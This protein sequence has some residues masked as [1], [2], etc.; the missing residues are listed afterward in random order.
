MKRLHLPFLFSIFLLLLSSCLFSQNEKFTMRQ[1]ACGLSQPWEIKFG[2]DGFLWATEAHSYQITRIDPATGNAELLID[3]SAKKNFPNF[4]LA[5]KF[6]QG[7]LQ[8]I[9]FH[10]SFNTNPYFYVAYVYRFD[11]CL[12]DTLG[13]YFKTKI[14]RY[15]Y[16]MRTKTLSNEMVIVDTIPG[17][18]DHNG[19][20]LAIGPISEDM[21]FLFYSVGDMAAGHLGNGARTHNGQN[22]N[23]YEGKILRFNLTPDSDSAYFNSWI[24]NNNPFNTAGKQSAVWSIGHRNPQGLAFSPTGILYES[25]HGPYSDDEINIIKP[26]YNYGFPLIMGYTDGNY[27]GSKAGAGSGVPFVTSEVA[28]QALIERTYPYGEPIGSFFPASRRDVSTFYTND[29]NNTPPYPNYYLQYPTSAPSGIDY[30]DS[31][32][33]PGWKNSILMA[34]LK[35]ANVYRLKLSNDGSAI[36]GDTIAYFQ[37]LGRFRDL[38][39]S[40]DGTKIY[41]STDTVGVVKGAPGV[42]VV[43]PNKGCILEFTL[44]STGT[45]D[46][47]LSD[48][49]KL[50]PNP[51]SNYFTLT[52][53]PEITSAEVSVSSSIGEKKIVAQKITGDAN[54]NIIDYKPGIYII[55]LVYDNK[56]WREK[57]FIK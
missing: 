41:V 47:S 30:Y 14:V 19:G 13:C 11:G 18:T 7:G 24:P 6:P 32:A 35:L 40:P 10:P 38:A 44:L 37:G 20:R 48:L 17:S 33:I 34:N 12:P 9:A 36:V 23:H 49:V 3:L 2:P 50:Y 42:A 51:A 27:D 46:P 29:Y 1:L 45:Y 4:N 26:G 54:F 39:I 28:N 16:D 53:H 43:P 15:F 25:E 21:D 22:P 5:T 52:L 8:G 31:D 55:E 56:L 57:L